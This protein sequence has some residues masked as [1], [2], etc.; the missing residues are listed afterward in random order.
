MLDRRR[1][2]IASITSSIPLVTGCTDS[3]SDDSAGDGAGDPDTDEGGTVDM[4]V[5]R[6]EAEATSSAIIIKTPVEN[7]GSIRATIAFETELFLDGESYSIN[8]H[9]VT[10]DPD[11]LREVRSEHEVSRID[12]ARSEQYSWDVRKTSEYEA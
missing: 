2:L 8:S 3:S 9:T 10:L 1:L 12:S 7:Y 6:G 5:G 11:E 4:W